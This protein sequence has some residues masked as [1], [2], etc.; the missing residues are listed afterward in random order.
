MTAID[1]RSDTVTKPTDEMRSAMA[2]AEVGDDVFGEDPSI[3]ELQERSAALLGKEAGLLTS[4]GT[5][6]NLIATLAWSN[7]GDE[8]IMG[9]EAHM[10]WNESAGQAALGGVQTRLVPNDS[11]GRINPDDVAAAIRPSG[12]LHFPRTS[13]IC[14]ENTHNRCSGGVLT[15]EDTKSVGDVAHAAGVPVHLDGARIFNASVA[16]EVPPAELARDVD[17]LSFCLSKSLSCP[18]GSVLVGSQDFI[19]NAKRWRKMLGGGMRQAGVLAAAGL[20]AL[21]TMIDRLAED[22]QHAKRLAAGLANIDGL[23][24][25]PESIQTNIVFFEVDE[26]LGTAADLIA[27]LNRNGVLVSYPGKQSI[28]MVTHRH[29]SPEDIEEALS[30]TSAAVRELRSAA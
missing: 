11:Q 17:D 7:H 8:I 27:A 10:F 25:D 28:R 9:T 21:D 26:D 14:L 22:H 12:N 5:M 4:S 23:T 18:V 30:R 6:S 3:N 2:T 13:M 20:V 29:I 24:V 19:D 15:P 16:L 1:L